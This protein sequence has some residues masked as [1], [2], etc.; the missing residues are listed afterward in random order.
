[1]K[2]TILVFSLVLLGAVAMKAQ[3]AIRPSVGVNSTV[4][5]GDFKDQAWR[6]ALGHQLGIDFQLGSKFYFQP[7]MHWESL[8]GYVNN[9]QTGVELDFN[10]SHIRVPVTLGCRLF[11]SFDLVNVRFFGG[12]DA[13]YKLKEDSGLL[14]FS[15]DQKGLRGA[16]FGYHAGMGLDLLFLFVDA[17]YRWSAGRFFGMDSHPNGARM[18]VFY[19]QAGLRIK[20]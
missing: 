15:T 13:S 7:G 2:N 17:G 11:N 4:L 14:H 20:L 19:A 8:H 3:F 16:R 12:L 1:M 10:S 6:S 9:T 18:D 5:T